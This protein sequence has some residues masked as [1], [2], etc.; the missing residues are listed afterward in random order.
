MFGLF[1][2][3]QAPPEASGQFPPVP[4]WQPEIAQPLERIVERF[5][6]YSNGSR[7]F[8]VFGHG[9]VVILPD[10]LGD[11]EAEKHAKQALHNVFHAHPDM[12]PRYMKDGNILVQYKHD[13]ASLVLSDI[14]DE[15][16]AEIDQRHQGALATSEVLI[17]PLGHNKFDD[18]GKKALFGRCYMFMD[19]QSPNVV[20]VVRHAR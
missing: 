15:H 13:V 9:T 5:R 18:F 20:R 14:A 1:K 2:K 16:W 17:T 3:K 7:D 8:A 4:D 12:H 6:F 10:G 11:A 19:A